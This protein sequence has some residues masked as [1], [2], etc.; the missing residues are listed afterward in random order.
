MTETEPAPGSRE[1]IARKPTSRR[2]AMI[3]KES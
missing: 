3:D 1:A 2:S